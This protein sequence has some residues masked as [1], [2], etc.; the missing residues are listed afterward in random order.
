MIDARLQGRAGWLV[1]L[2]YMAFTLVP[3][4]WL[5]NIA[6]KSN[7]ETLASFTLWPQQPTLANFMVIFTDVS[8]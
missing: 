8:W 6:L 5:F 4:Y 2:L 1:L 7:E 3:L